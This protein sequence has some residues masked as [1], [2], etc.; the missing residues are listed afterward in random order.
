MC[1]CLWCVFGVVCV[2]VVLDCRRNVTLPR[3]ALFLTLTFHAANFPSVFSKVYSTAFLLFLS[4][5]LLMASE[6]ASLA[7]RLHLV[8][9]HL[10]FFH[11]LSLIDF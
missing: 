3:Q 9:K 10:E 11:F 8:S 4:N 5:V 2:C 6:T 7:H 1:V